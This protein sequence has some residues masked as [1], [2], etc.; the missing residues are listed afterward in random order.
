MLVHVYP[1]EELTCRAAAFL[2]AAQLTQKPDS[3]FG[4]ATGSTPIPCYK[5]LISFY[6]QGL[7]D[8][9]Q[10]IS[11]NLDEYCGIAQ[12]HPSSYHRFMH[13]NLF[14]HIN[15][16][17]ENIH[18]PNSMGVDAC[19][20][21]DKAIEQAGGIDLQL[22][23]IGKN[24][25]IGFNEPDDAFSCG[26]HIVKLTESTIAANARFF[27]DE[28]DVPRTAISMGISSIMACH[29]IVLIA[30]GESKA[31]AVYDTLNGPI[32]P[33]VPASILRLHPNATFLL[34]QDAASML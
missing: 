12:D 25:H 20:R 5:D 11:F 18:I 28:K 19:E 24:G 15:I 33:H 22:L 32:N 8:F 4:F 14:S 34:D 17:K 6:E 27:K 7:L 16:P 13:E 21:Y 1:A 3:V 26:T 31:K 2:F 30:T 10:V 23:G 9:S 29:S